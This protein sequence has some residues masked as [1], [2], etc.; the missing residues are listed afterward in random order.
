MKI[1]VDKMPEFPEKCPFFRVKY[2]SYICKL[3][4]D[5]PISRCYKTDYCPYLITL[6]GYLN[7]TYKE[8]L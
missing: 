5:S 2:R 1:I 3:D 8:V 7:R 6:E 4:E